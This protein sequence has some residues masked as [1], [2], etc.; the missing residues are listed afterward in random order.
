M[1][2]IHSRRTIRPTISTIP[3]NQS[4]ATKQLELYKMVTKR[5]RIQQEL[6]F[7]EQRLQV[8]KQQ[9]SSLDNQIKITEKTIQDLR[10]S[11]P[12]SSESATPQTSPPCSTASHKDVK[13]S[14]KFQTFYLEY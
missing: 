11:P 1:N 2:N 9:M 10:Q 3:R 12:A 14:S 8:L 13:S 6:Q 7:M 4:E 5:Q